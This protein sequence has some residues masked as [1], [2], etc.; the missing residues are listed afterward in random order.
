MPEVIYYFRLRQS[1]SACSQIISIT[2]LEM[3]I[4]SGHFVRP[5]VIDAME[6][7][8]AN[9]VSIRLKFIHSLGLRKILL[10]KCYRKVIL[11][12]YYLAWC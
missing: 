2:Q 11:N 10:L 9:L 7:A 5:V 1:H 4:T 3:N 6:T 8:A 12:F